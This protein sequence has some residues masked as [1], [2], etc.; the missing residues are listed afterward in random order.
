MTAK[1]TPEGLPIVT[2]EAQVEFNREQEESPDLADL[3]DQQIAEIYR[4]NPLAISYVALVTSNYD[5]HHR[6]TALSYCSGL[7]RL[8]QKQT[9]IN[10][11]EVSLPLVTLKAISE[12]FREF[13]E[14]PLE[15]YYPEKMIEIAEKTPM[16]FGY[17]SSV[18]HLGQI[19]PLLNATI[20]SGDVFGLYRI[21]QIQAERDKKASF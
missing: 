20:V 7:Y 9:E 5:N 4:T 18:N 17:I 2:L 10:G 8:M 13:N 6:E 16:V 14:T 19:D 15:T 12:F 1:H 3:I 11:S 21:L